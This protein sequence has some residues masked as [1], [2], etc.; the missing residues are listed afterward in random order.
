MRLPLISHPHSAP[1]EPDAESSDGLL[2]GIKV[3]LVDDSAEVLATLSMLLEMECAD[4]DAFDSPH[5]AP[6]AAKTGTYDV[7]ISDICQA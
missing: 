4:I 2:S 7:I 5:R 1:S 6:E 3:L